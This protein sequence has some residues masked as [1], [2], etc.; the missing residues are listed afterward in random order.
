ML[1]EGHRVGTY[2]PAVWDT[3]PDARLFLRDLK[4]KAGL[5]E[6]YWSSTLE[7]SRYTVTTLP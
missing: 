3:L 5:P 6:G 1:R 4:K 2:L 7:L